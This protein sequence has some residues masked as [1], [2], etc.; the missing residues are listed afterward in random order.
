M[1]KRNKTEFVAVR[2]TD[3]QLSQVDRVSNGNRS[4]YIRQAVAE[5]LER[6]KEQNVRQ[7]RFISY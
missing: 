2:M 7:E 4:E 1:T 5:K 6:E 3:E